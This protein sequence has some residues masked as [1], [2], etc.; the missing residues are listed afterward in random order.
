MFVFHI[1]DFLR[2]HTNT[3]I[4]VE[5][6]FAFIVVLTSSWV[7]LLLLIHVLLKE[8]CGVVCFLLSVIFEYKSKPESSILLE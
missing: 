7:L 1:L 4:S 8:L 6:G 3:F 2:N 5:L